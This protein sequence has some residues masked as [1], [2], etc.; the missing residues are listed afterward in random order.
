M[1]WVSS[2]LVYIWDQLTVSAVWNTG[3]T[4]DIY[5][6]YGVQGTQLITYF[7]LHMNKYLSNQIIMGLNWMVILGMETP[8][9]PTQIQILLLIFNKLIAESEIWQSMFDSQATDHV[10]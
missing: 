5:C 2:F 6:V 1:E 8:I 3:E 10:S 7:W 9:T 4:G